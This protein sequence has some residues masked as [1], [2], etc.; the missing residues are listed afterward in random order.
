MIRKIPYSEIDFDKYERCIGNALQKNFYAKKE[1]LDFLCEKWELLIYGDYDYVMPIPISKKFGFN[2]VIQ[3]LFCQ[4][5]GVFS[6]KINSKIEQDFLLFFYKNYNIYQYAFNSGNDI[7]E[8]LLFKNNYIIPKTEYAILR[9]KYFKGRKSAVK[10]AQNLQFRNLFLSDETLAFIKT[11]T[12]GLP[13]ASDFE[14][15]IQYLNFLHTRN[16]LKLYGAFLENQLLN[17]AVI[18]EDDDSH[19]LLGLMNDPENIKKDGS[20]FLIDQILQNTISTKDFSFMGSSIRG[21]EV[22]FKSFGSE[23]RR[24]P[25]ISH[26]KKQLIGSYFNRL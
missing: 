7:H 6:S 10:S 2:V 9:K 23:L 26:N 22:F 4:Q 25:V 16:H 14:F 5:L 20:S 19:Y 24:F 8:K 15:F 3:P 13:K 1:I 21:I 18:V 17:L 11:H 12:L